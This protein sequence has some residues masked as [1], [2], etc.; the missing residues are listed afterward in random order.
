MIDRSDYGVSKPRTGQLHV[1][2]SPNTGADSFP[3]SMRSSTVLVISL[4]G[5]A[6]EIIKNLVLAGIGKLIV[7][8]NEVVT[9]EDLGTGFLFR[10]E[11]G[12]V[13]KAVRLRFPHACLPSWCRKVV[14]DEKLIH[15]ATEGD[16]CGCTDFVPQPSR[17]A[18]DDHYH[19]TPGTLRRGRL[20]VVQQHQQPGSGLVTTGSGQRG[21]RLRS[22]AIPDGQLREVVAELKYPAD[23]CRRASMRRQEKRVSCFTR[24]A[25]TGSTAMRLPTSASSLISSI[26][27]SPRLL[28]SNRYSA[29]LTA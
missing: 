19:R 28:I 22:A 9:E 10:E 6:H 16:G 20:C 4:K 11:D 8:D 7:M 2:S 23:Q 27:M 25:R 13:G 21:G 17:R 29:D 14:V 24:L 12:A 18:P 15:R 5:V 26:R 1:S 3:V